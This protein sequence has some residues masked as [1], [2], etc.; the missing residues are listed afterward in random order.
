[1]SEEA[2][3]AEAEAPEPSRRGVLKSL[4]IVGGGL[5]L[6]VGVPK[7]LSKPAAAAPTGPPKSAKEIAEALAE[8]NARFVAGTSTHPHLDAQVRAVQAEKQTPFAAVLGCAD[9][10]VSP[11]LVFDQGIGDLFTVRVA[12]NI[13]SA[14]VVASLAY[15]VEHLAVTYILVLGHEGC[16]AVKAAVDARTSGV[17]APEFAVLINALMPAVEKAAEKETDSAKLALPSVVANARMVATALPR[18]SAILSEAIEKHELTIAAA[19]YSITTAGVT[20]LT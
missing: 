10:R 1:M 8:G 5:A 19:T 15:A 14:D 9:S 20:Y 12:G 17:V 3:E 18:A 4:M 6:G 13:A 7:V 2:V 11:E 16:G